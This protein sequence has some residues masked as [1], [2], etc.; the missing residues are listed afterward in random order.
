MKFKNRLIRSLMAFLSR[1]SPASLAIVSYGLVLVVAAADLITGASLA[2]HVFYLA[3]IALE[4]WFGSRR[5]TGYIAIACTAAWITCDVLSGPRRHPAIHV[6]NGT[7]Q[8]LAFSLMG[9]LVARVKE[10]LEAERSI[11]RVDALTGILNRR[12]FLERLST[13][14]LRARRDGTPLAA[15]VLDLD[16]FKELN[17]RFGHV[18]GDHALAQVAATLRANLRATDVA[19]RLGGDE[20][21]VIIPNTPPLIVKKV[22][23]K[24]QAAVRGM[25]QAN[26]WPLSGSM[27]AVTYVN[28]PTDTE[29]MLTHADRLMY[30]A[31]AAGDGDVRYE[32]VEL[33]SFYAEGARSRVIASPVKGT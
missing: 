33:G 26:G 20:F 17:D 21:A 8:L 12:G 28:V 5:R 2:F 7:V 29:E 10:V 19:A 31:K 24:L 30:E 9:L 22:L 14:V 16:R 32:I 27:G 18:A 15:A 11:A 1:L 23:Q 3:P 25:A 4:A 6:W 13:E